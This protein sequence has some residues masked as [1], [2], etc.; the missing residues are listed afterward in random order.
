MGQN[1]RETST[2][3]WTVAML[4]FSLQIYEE[5]IYD[6]LRELL[7]SVQFKK[8]EKHPWRSVTFSK[9]AGFSYFTKSNTRPWMFFTFFKLYKWYQIAQRMAI[10]HKWFSIASFCKAT[11][12][13]TETFKG[14]KWRFCWKFLLQFLEINFPF[15]SPNPSNPTLRVH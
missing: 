11:G 10:L 1:V 4:V 9:V 13:K 3:C 6:A 7:P 5:T 8:R 12:A 2:K 15:P 14:N